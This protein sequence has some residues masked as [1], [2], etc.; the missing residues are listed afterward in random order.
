[1]K[2]VCVDTNMLIW[3]IKRQCTKGQEDYLDKADYLFNYLE[4]NDIQI[5]IPSVVVAEL[6]GNVEDEDEREKYFD[7]ISENFEIAQHDVVSARRF[8]GLKVK[9]L[10]TNAEQYRKQNNIPKC[11]ITNDQNICCVAL[12]SGCDTIFSHNLKDFEKFANHEIN[13]L[14][15]DYVDTLKM[16]EEQNKNKLLKI[17][18]NQVTLNLTEEDST[19]E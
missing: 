7:Y 13:I 16:E 14:T 5:V 15:L 3:Y 11:Q 17:D 10:K 12:S 2:K 18:P 6:L 4:K 8:V 9:L 19:Q 1:M